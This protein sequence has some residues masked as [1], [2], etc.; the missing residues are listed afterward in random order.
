MGFRY[1]LNLNFFSIFL[2]Y[3]SDLSSAGE[4]PI[5]RRKSLKKSLRESFR[6]LRRGRTTKGSSSEE[7]RGHASPIKGHTIGSPIETR[8]VERQI[9]ARPVDDSMGGT[10]RC[11]HLANTFLISSKNSMMTTISKI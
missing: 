7:K 9:E 8:P 5:S 2:N 3:L 10:V 1:R 4:G 6:R 11:V